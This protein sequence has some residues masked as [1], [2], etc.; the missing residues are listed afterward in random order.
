MGL[1]II[2]RGGKF[3]A[4]ID[5]KEQEVAMKG[6][7]T[8]EQSAAELAAAKTAGAVEARADVADDNARALLRHQQRD[9]AADAARPASDDGDLA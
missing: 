2:E 8:P 9:A 1:E 6:G 7:K 3:F 4:T 5:G